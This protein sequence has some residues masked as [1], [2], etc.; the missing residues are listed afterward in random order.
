MSKKIKN[1]LVVLKAAPTLA[2]VPTTPPDRCHQ[3]SGDRKG[4]FAV[5]L[6]QPFRIVFVPNDTEKVSEIDGG[7][8]KQQVTAI[9]IVDVADYH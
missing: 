3:L 2:A 9:T 1:R 7:I 6:V 8:D 5:D 4:Q